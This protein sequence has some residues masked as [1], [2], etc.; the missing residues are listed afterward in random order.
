MYKRSPIYNLMGD[1]F[2]MRDT[3]K[4]AFT[5]TKLIGVTEAKGPGIYILMDSMN[6]KGFYIGKGKNMVE[7][8]RTHVVK[9]LG[10]EHTTGGR[11]APTRKFTAYRQTR[12]SS[13]F[14]N[15]SDVKVAFWLTSLGDQNILED[16]ITEAYCKKYGG[17]PVCNSA[18]MCKL[19]VLPFDDSE[20]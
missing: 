2:E 18:S 5:N 4:S 15:I 16:N 20:I 19:G 8:W 6:P 12:F 13:G 17:P 14:E 11:V 10:L 1:V 9:L 3:S 7:R